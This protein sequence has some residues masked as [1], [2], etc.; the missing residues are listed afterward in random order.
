[1]L[2]SQNSLSLEMPD[3]P[4]K[5]KPIYDYYRLEFLPDG[6]PGKLSN[7]GLTIHPH[8]IYGPYV[9]FDYLKLFKS[10][11][12]NIYLRA[13]ETVA[14]AGVKRMDQLEGAMVF[15]YQPNQVS[16]HNKKYYSGLTQIRWIYACIGLY[17]VTQNHKYLDIAKQIYSSFFIPHEKGGV[18]YES[19]LGLSIEELPDNP[20]GMVLNGWLSVIYGL[21][22]LPK[23]VVDDRHQKLIDGNYD[24]L[25]RLLPLYDVPSVK[26]SRYQLRGIAQFKATIEKESD[27]NTGGMFDQLVSFFNTPL[28]INFREMSISIPGFEKQI[29][30][31]DNNGL[32]EN[33]ISKKNISDDNRIIL[34]SDSL[35]FKSIINY[36]SYPKENI[37]KFELTS[38]HKAKLKLY[39]GESGYNPLSSSVAPKQYRE[40]ATFSIHEGHNVISAPLAWHDLELTAY[41]TNFAKKVS[42]RNCN[43]YHYIHVILLKNLHDKSGRSAF[44]TYSEKWKEYIRE[45]PNLLPYVESGALLDKSCSGN[46]V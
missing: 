24:L 15:W 21:E 10:T 38:N 5:R 42:G 20:P 22:H 12:D 33:S 30:S 36:I 40:I 6:Y 26:N 29:I 16:A 27:Y 43:S 32:W 9:I 17:E 18:L 44:K 41:P 2:V 45:W 34:K 37:L 11:K 1:M 3:L 7:D 14:E 35:K 39:I 13:A 46:S 25:E 31:P 8:P 23:S 19:E 28:E 4:E